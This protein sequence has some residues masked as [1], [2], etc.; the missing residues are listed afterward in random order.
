MSHC[1]F[2]TSINYAFAEEQGIQNGVDPCFKAGS[3]VPAADSPLVDAGVNDLSWM[4]TAYDLQ[5]KPDGRPFRKRIYNGVVD[6][7]A[8]E[9]WP[10]PGLLLKVR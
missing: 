3:Y 8:Y 5:R 2:R 6:I 4:A 7:G 10:V 9:Y 1:L